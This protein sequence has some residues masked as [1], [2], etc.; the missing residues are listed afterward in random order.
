VSETAGRRRVSPRP[1]AGWRRLWRRELAHYPGAGARSAYVVLVVAVTIVLYYQQYVGGAVSVSVLSH[2]QISFRYYLTIIVVS[3]GAG[4][5]ASLVAGLADRW[6]RANLVVGGLLVAASVTAF[7]IPAAANAAQYALLVSV[8]GFVEGL[9]LVATPALVRDF[10]AQSG[11]G[12]AMGLW[13]LG[14]VVGSLVVAEV[15]SHTL[16]SL[17]AWQDQFHIAGFVGLGVAALALVFLRELTPS[18]RDQLLVSWRDRALVEA[19]ARGVDLRGALRQPW[20][21]MARVDILVPA[22]G[23]SLFLL[24]YFAAVAFFVLYF[25]TVFGFSQARSNSVGNWF[26]AIDAVTVVAIGALSDRSRVRKPF[27]VAGALGAIALT[28]V[29]AS[30]ATHP[31]TSYKTLVL[32]VS[33]LSLFRGMAYAPW[34]AAFSE[35]VERR[36][37]ALVATGLALWGWVLRLVVVVSFLVLPAVVASVTPVADYGSHLAAIDARYGPEVHTLQAIDPRTRAALRSGPP[38]AGALTTAVEEVAAR[39][40]VPPA[41]AVVRLLALRRVPPADRAYLAAHGAAVV[42]ARRHAPV[43]WLHWW[44]IC[45]AGE[46]VFL[47]T[48]FLLYGRWRPSSARRDAEEHRRLVD[49]ELSR[50]GAGA[51]TGAAAATVSAATVMG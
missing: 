1:S 40:R 14:P 19:Q 21:Q 49:E 6:G 13:T 32:I 20:R 26:W 51:S 2:F 47:P 43:Q 3:N 12:R 35:T 28:L 34:M 30:R 17:P 42:E 33:M 25:T 15:S 5:L 39:F 11:R 8:V 24:I 50:I 44:W 23:V 18:L 4:A 41:D 38:P 46:V 22:V 27:M 16:G 48:I 10:S 37:P 45:T 7:A 31:A 29:F 9:V 36:N